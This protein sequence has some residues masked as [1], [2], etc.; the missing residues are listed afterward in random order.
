MT[1]PGTEAPIREADRD[2]QLRRRDWRF[3]RPGTSLQHIQPP[4]GSALQGFAGRNPPGQGVYAEW[5]YPVPGGGATIRKRLKSSGFQDVDLYWPWPGLRRPWFW[6]PLGS[7]AAAAYVHAT[8]LPARSLL[9][10][11]L[12][13]PLRAVWRWAAA[14][15]RLW[16]ICAVARVS[17][18]SSPTHDLL[19]RIAREWAAWGL[20]QPPGRLS[21]LLLTR[22][23]RSINKVVGLVFAEP[24]PSPRLVVKLPRAPDVHDA[25]RREAAVL[26]AVHGRLP[27]GLPGAPRVL[28]CDEQSGGLTLCETALEGRPLFSLLA[29]S[30][31]RDLAMK[32]TE[33]LAEL[34]GM[35]S[36]AGARGGANEVGAITQEF[37]TM[38]G[39]VLNPMELWT[40]ERLLATLADLPTVPEHRDFSPWNVHIARDGA[41][42]VYDWESA[43]PAGFPLNDLIYFLSYLAFFYE[44][45]I[46]SGRC[47]ESYRRARDPST[48]TGGVYRDCLAHYCE[49]I[50]LDPRHAAAL[51]LLTWIIHSRSEYRRL[52]AD[53]G[54]QPAAAALAKSLFLQLWREELRR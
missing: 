29:K 47:T 19:D 3:L 18:S 12:D 4:T 45:A 52:V 41:L 53:S 26:R 51:H 14:R 25:L 27:N 33:W 38:F 40:T 2:R 49:R 28:F 8:R 21:W 32:A 23:A 20:G 7:E 46:S 48:F 54:G 22:G 16:P 13:H 24:D 37:A 9:R 15:Q 34:A 44:R 31:Y 30:T 10:R 35:P 39:A 42:A 5:R 43:E 50:G 17:D 36:D 6:L 1:E 11:V